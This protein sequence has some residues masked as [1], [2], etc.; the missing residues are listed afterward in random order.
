MHELQPVPRIDVI[1]LVQALYGGR[2]VLAALE[3][4]AAT[5]RGRVVGVFEAILQA[6]AFQVNDLLGPSQNGGKID[7]DL[8]YLQ[9]ILGGAAGLMGDPGRG[10]D[11]LPACPP[12]TTRT[13]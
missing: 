12:P 8:G 1:D 4:G 13:S 2:S 9:A 3:A 11:G 6:A 10:D 7:A 5:D